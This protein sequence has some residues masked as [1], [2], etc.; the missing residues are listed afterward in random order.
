V[1]APPSVRRTPWVR[2]FGDHETA[3]ASGWMQV[4]GMRRRRGLNRGFALSDHADWPALLRTA[5]ESRARRVLCTHG[6]AETLARFLREERGLDAEALPTRFEGE[7]G[8]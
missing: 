7:E 5:H 3:F 1:L 8:A 4:R 6:Y 2:R